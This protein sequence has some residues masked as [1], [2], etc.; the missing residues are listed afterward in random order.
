[1]RPKRIFLV[2]HAQSEGN[3][4]FH[5]Y[6]TLSDP[7]IPLTTVGEQQALATGE[8]L[9]KIVGHETV[10]FYVSP[11]RR[12]RET[13]EFLIRGMEL[14]ENQYIRYE[15]PRLREQDWGNFR[16]VEA[17]EPIQKERYEYSPFFYR[18]PNG[19]S[20]ADVFDRVST[21]LETLYR[22]FEKPYYPENVII[23]SHGLAIRLFFMRWYHWS[24]EEFESLANPQ[25]AQWLLMELADNNK[26]ILTTPLEQYSETDEDI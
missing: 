3:V 9:K 19:E 21:F 26:Y 7:K 1:M 5:L 14:K 24:V 11:Y 15:D 2:R 25:N 22:G 6:E 18:F 12:T 10:Q 17:L 4:N 23:V 20:G 8:E 16:S 13:S